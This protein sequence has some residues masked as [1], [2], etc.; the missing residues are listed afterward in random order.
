M[1]DHNDQLDDLINDNE[2]DVYDNE[3]SFRANE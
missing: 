3:P 2:L 1:H